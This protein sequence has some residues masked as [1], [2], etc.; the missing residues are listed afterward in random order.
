MSRPYPLFVLLSAGRSKEDGADCPL[1][2][3]ASLPPSLTNG[4]TMEKYGAVG[5][6][7]L[8]GSFDPAEEGHVGGVTGGHLSVV[9]TVGMKRAQ[10]LS[11]RQ[12]LSILQKNTTL[13]YTFLLQ[14]PS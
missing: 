7:I 4:R 12:R 3:A 9:V 6:D 8:G 5:G 10:Y 2:G 1:A 13:I 14:F 11:Y